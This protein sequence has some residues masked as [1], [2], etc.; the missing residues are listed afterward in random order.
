[1]E[2]TTLG[3]DLA[4]NIFELCGMDARGK[5]I[6]RKKLSRNKF[7]PFIAQLSRC[8][9]GMEACGG[10]HHWARKFAQYGHEVRLIS[11]QFVKPFV[12]TNKTDRADAEAICEAVQRPTMRFVP[13]KSVEQQDIQALHRVRDRLVKNRTALS[14]EMRGVLQEYGIVLPKTIAALKRYLRTQLEETDGELTGHGVELLRSLQQE[15]DQL[16]AHIEGVEAKINAVCKAHPI[17]QRL[18]SI[19]GVGPLSATALV[20]TVG[21]AEQFKNGREFAAYLGLVPRQ[22]S[23]GGKAQLLGIST[24]G[25]PYLR[26]LLIHGAR[27]VLHWAHKY[28]DRRSQWIQ[29]VQARRGTNRAVVALAN[30][31]A[32]VI[33]VLMTRDE[34]YRPLAAV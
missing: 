2:L 28:T 12:K 15:L 22:H 23:S 10:S 6:L 5:V 25:D 14:N 9:I 24:R 26:K 27:S 21:A 11:P 33:W 31:N 32:R 3:I 17:C 13:M 30:K 16:E 4:K 7:A 34:R 18:L 8:V 20:A 29:Q 19:P 1:M